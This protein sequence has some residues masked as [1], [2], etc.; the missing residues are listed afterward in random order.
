MHFGLK[1]GGAFLWRSQAKKYA[2]LPTLGEGLALAITG[3]M[4]PE[5][6]SHS[7]LADTKVW[8]R[9][10]LEALESHMGGVGSRFLFKKDLGLVSGYTGCI[11]GGKDCGTF[12]AKGNSN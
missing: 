5:V 10:M 6:P 12:L 7:H 4:P 11:L 1:Q 3:L 2:N 9:S 8:G